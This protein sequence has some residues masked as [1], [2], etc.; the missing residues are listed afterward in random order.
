[1]STIPLVFS[2]HVNRLLFSILGH[3]LQIEKC[4]IQDLEMNHFFGCGLLELDFN[5]LIRSTAFLGDEITDSFYQT[6]FVVQTGGA[7][8]HWSHALSSL[9]DSV[10]ES[11][12]FLDVTIF[13]LLFKLNAINKCGGRVLEDD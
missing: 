8:N 5:L 10:G 4:V 13:E 7:D 1:M 9:T 11:S 12:T 3:K 6:D 2:N